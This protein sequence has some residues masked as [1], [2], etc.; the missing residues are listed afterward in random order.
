[1]SATA[2]WKAAHPRSRGEN[3]PKARTLS[4]WQGSSP[5]TRGKPGRFAV[6]RFAG[7]LIPAHAGKTQAGHGMNTSRRAHPRSRG[8]NE[9][10]L[11]TI[12]RYAGSSP[13]TRGKRWR[14][15]AVS[16]TSGLI[17]AHAGKTPRGSAKL[18]D[19]RAHPRSRGENRAARDDCGQRVGSSPLTRGKHNG[20]TRLARDTGLIPAHAGKTPTGRQSTGGP[21]AHPR[22]RGENRRGVVRSLGSG[23]S[24]PLTR[25]KP[26]SYTIHRPQCRLIPAHAGK[27]R[28]V[29]GPR[30]S[31]GAHPRSRGENPERVP[32][33]MPAR[34]SSPLTRGKLRAGLEA[35]GWAGLIPAHAGKTPVPG[36]QRSRSRAH[37]RSRGENVDG[38]GFE[39]QGQGS[40]PLTRGKLQTHDRPW[41]LHGLIPAHAGKTART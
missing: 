41:R 27:T 11:W 15:C 31:Q 36:R 14:G 3:S 21:G 20:V 5:L 17:P 25:G 4:A 34:G 23:G 37:P 33:A 24:S 28:G 12:A 22:S 40:S 38:S 8:E 13:L 9:G 10:K 18:R 7:R 29:A 19:A 35:V 30:T 39:W 1:M 26:D 32:V 16:R 6:W 2:F